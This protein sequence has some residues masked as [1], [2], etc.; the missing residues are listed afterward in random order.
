MGDKIVITVPGDIDLIVRQAQQ[1]AA[2]AGGTMAGD[3]RAGIFAG[4]TP[5]GAIKGTYAV[6][7]QTVTI[8]AYRKT[9]DA[10]S[11]RH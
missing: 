1:V 2:R 3:F 7:G 11:G 10:A 4:Q 6:T 9:V 8:N 5:L